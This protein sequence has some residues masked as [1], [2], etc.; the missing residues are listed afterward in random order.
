MYFTSI[1]SD[2][3]RQKLAATVES[4]KEV[5]DCCVALIFIVEQLTI[6]AL[7]F[8]IRRLF[9]VVKLVLFRFLLNGDREVQMCNDNDGFIKFAIQ[10]VELTTELA[11]YTQ[12][13][14]ES[15]SSATELDQLIAHVNHVTTNG[16]A[17]H[18]STSKCFL[19]SILTAV[20]EVLHC[21]GDPIA[22][23]VRDATF[24]SLVGKARACVEVVQGIYRENSLV[25]GL[26]EQVR[27]CYLNNF[28]RTRMTL[29]TLCP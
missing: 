14:P 8:R 12:S 13:L 27:I 15:S 19:E 2:R 22:S 10:L 16:V 4:L 29:R 5:H 3:Y 23:N 9:Q 17:A 28:L 24:S 18:M 11:G 26:I 7:A 6:E 20:L 1:P 25:M 21:P